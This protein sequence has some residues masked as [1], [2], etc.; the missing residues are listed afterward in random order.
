MTDKTDRAE[1]RRQTKQ[2][3]KAI[4]D[5]LK[6]E[7]VVAPNGQV[8]QVGAVNQKVPVEVLVQSCVQ[9]ALAM[10]FGAGRRHERNQSAIVVAPGNVQLPDPPGGQ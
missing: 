10:S 1:R 8:L 4:H 2:Q 5:A 6:I 9:A 3:A 7:I